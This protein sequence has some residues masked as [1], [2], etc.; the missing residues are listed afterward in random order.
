[1]VVALTLIAAFLFALAATLQQKGAL[2]LPTIS[3]SDPK[4]IARLAGQKVW[5]LGLLCVIAAD[6]FQAAALDH[7]RLVI[8]QPLLVTTVVFAL[9][10]GYV[11]T[12]Q[13]VGRPEI[14]GS[15][16]IVLGLALFTIFG[17]PAGGRDNAPG[18][19]WAAAILVIGAVCGLLLTFGNRGGPSTKAAVYGTASGMLFGLAAALA[20]PTV[21]ELHDGLS[22]VLSYWETYALMVAGVLAF[23]LQQVSLGTGRLAPS[24]ATVCVANPVVGILIGTLLLEERLQRPTWHVVVAV[25]GLGL[26]LVG[27]VVISFAHEG[28]TESAPAA[29]PAPVPAE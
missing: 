22:V 20:K 18:G 10:L 25:I 9:P 26:A 16:T 19:E 15:I 3:L 29:E 13:P 6:V 1:M 27:A 7:G 11:L 14:L 5:L 28:R 12:R 17:A 2:N 4:S 8:V 23:A 24:V 21:E